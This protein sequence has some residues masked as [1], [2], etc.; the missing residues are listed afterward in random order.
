LRKAFTLIELLVVIAIIA[1]LAAILFPVFAQAKDAAKKTANISQFKQVGISMLIYNGDFDDRFP[2]AYNAQTDGL[3]RTWP[4]YA[5]TDYPAPVRAN[6]AWQFDVQW[7]NSTMPYR[8]N[9]QIS[10][11]V[12]A[13]AVPV[14]F[15]NVTFVN[16]PA[17]IGQTFNGL[18]STYSGSALDNPS[19]VPLIWAGLGKVNVTGL[20]HVNPMLWCGIV[21][22]ASGQRPGMS[23]QF[24]PGGLPNPNGDTS[25]FQGGVQVTFTD[26]S[27]NPP[28]HWL[29][30]Q[31]TIIVRSD[32]SAKFIRIG[33]GTP[34]ASNGNPFGDPWSRYTTANNGTPTGNYFGCTVSAGAASLSNPI[35]PCFFRPDRPSN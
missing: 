23:C 15:G 24:A 2:I 12:A 11:I 21:P 4:I 19:S 32:T 7:A 8:K 29:H 20:A 33:M 28:T 30:S 1:I 17:N 5:S 35:Y 27:G 13:P 22:K 3:L 9:T 18:L 26:A 25:T 6:F 10:E 31:G 34:T 16:K 14:N